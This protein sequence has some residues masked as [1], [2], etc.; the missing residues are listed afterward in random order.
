MDDASFAAL[1]RLATAATPIRSHSDL[2]YMPQPPL[3]VCE[4]FILLIP[5]GRLDDPWPIE[6]GDENQACPERP[7]SPAPPMQLPQA[8]RKARGRDR[9]QPREHCSAL[10]QG[11][12]LG[13]K[14]GLVV[15]QNQEHNQH[16]GKAQGD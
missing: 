16:H 5:L 2:L 6:P 9:G 14:L 3:S 1:A 12:E 13:A 11:T 7:N 4:F 10:Q 8:S 15:A